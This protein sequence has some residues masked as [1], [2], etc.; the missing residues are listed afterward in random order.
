MR[1]EGSDFWDLIYA[2][3]WLVTWPWAILLASSSLFCLCSCGELCRVENAAVKYAT[4]AFSKQASC[5]NP[6][7]SADTNTVSPSSIGKQLKVTLVFSLPLIF[8]VRCWKQRCWN[9]A[10]F[11]LWVKRDLKNFDTQNSSHPQPGEIRRGQGCSW[12]EPSTFGGG[13]W[14]SREHC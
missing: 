9:P 14:E 5:G 4:T 11:V 3:Q 1:L 7:L 2:W 10:T 12:A 13:W 8:Q 6:Y